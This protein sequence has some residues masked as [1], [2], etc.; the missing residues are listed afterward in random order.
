MIDRLEHA[1]SELVF[2]Q[3]QAVLLEGPAALR[4]D[5]STRGHSWS[6]TE[7]AEQRPIRG[8]L[9]NPRTADH[10][11]A[12]IAERVD[13]PLGGQRNVRICVH[14]EEEDSHAYRYPAFVIKREERIVGDEGVPTCQGVE[15][16]AELSRLAFPE[17]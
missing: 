13:Y 3:R 14:A 12:E 16:F 6:G 11:V 10:V 17:G 5:S 7:G 4:D 15:D 2:Q 1:S 8:E 9:S